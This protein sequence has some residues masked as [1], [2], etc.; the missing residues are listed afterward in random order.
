LTLDFLVFHGTNSGGGPMRCRLF[1]VKEEKNAGYLV[2]FNIM[3]AVKGYTSLKTTCAPRVPSPV[4]H[5][6]C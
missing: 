4:G 5:K 1:F 3:N 2:G 6:P